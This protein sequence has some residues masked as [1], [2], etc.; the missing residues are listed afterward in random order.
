M[1]TGLN[2]RFGLSSLQGRGGWK[3]PAN[4]AGSS[5]GRFQLRNL[6]DLLNLPIENEA[7]VGIDPIF[8][9]DQ[10]L[11]SLVEVTFKA[12]LMLAVKRP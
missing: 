9:R 6:Q 11:I 5:A 2:R 3:C 12:G 4:I 7:R 8:I 10:R 1:A